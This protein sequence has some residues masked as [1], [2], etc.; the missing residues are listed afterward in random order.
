MS[1]GFLLG[2]GGEGAGVRDVSLV[3]AVFEDAGDEVFACGIMVVAALASGE[4]CGAHRMGIFRGA[5][6]ELLD[7]GAVDL[8]DSLAYAA[9]EA[10]SAIVKDG[11]I[12]VF[13]FAFFYEVEFVE[14]DVVALSEP[15]DEIVFGVVLLLDEVA[16]VFF[17]VGDKECGLT[18][19]EDLLEGG[20]DRGLVVAV[21]CRAYDGVVDFGLGKLEGGNL[22]VGE[23]VEVGDA[24]GTA[25]LVDDAT[26][27]RLSL[28]GG[29]GE[30][31]TVGEVDID[32]CPI[33]EGFGEGLGGDIAV[34]I[35]AVK[36]G[37]GAGSESEDGG[38]EGGRAG[39]AVYD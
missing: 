2:G 35:L 1:E 8:S 6:D 16:V 9:E 29:I 10:V 32:C 27:E 28:W 13:V 4:V 21:A 33:V 11:E 22:S 38:D 25:E 31:H 24:S 34:Q 12:E 30:L 7:A 23:G 36:G 37:A 20:F 5:E 39:S 3:A 15:E 14:D 19:L 18:F 26:E 17:E